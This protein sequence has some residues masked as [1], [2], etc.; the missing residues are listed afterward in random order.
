MRP[1]FGRDRFSKGYSGSP[2]VENGEVG[3][4]PEHRAKCIQD[5]S[6]IVPARRSAIF[7]KIDEHLIVIVESDEALSRE[8]N[9]QYN[10]YGCGQR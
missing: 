9:L 6:S 3:E 1:G 10:V 2:V 7:E 5:A 8:L 4:N